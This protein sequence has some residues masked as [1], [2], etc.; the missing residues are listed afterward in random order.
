[1]LMTIE[2]FRNYFMCELLPDNL[3]SKVAFHFN[4]S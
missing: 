2:T 4:V 3:S 1:M